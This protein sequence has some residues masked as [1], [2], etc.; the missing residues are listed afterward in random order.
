MSTTTQPEGNT[1]A[2][3]ATKKAASLIDENLHRGADVVS[4]MAR[5]TADCF[6]RA[7]D[8]VQQQGQKLKRQATHVGETATQHPAYTL[9]IV[10]AVGFTLGFLFRGSRSRA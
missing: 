8:F 5:Q 2:R 9:L 3:T 6:E 4:N 1:F 10:G 7:T